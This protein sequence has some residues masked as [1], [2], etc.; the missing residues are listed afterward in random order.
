[1]SR[2][3]PLASEELGRTSEASSGAQILA[4]SETVMRGLY[5]GTM[6]ALAIAVVTGVLRTW[7]WVLALEPLALG[8]VVGE[9]AAAPSSARHRQPPRWSYG[10]IFGVSFAAYL[11]IHLIFWLASTGIPPSMSLFDFLRAAPTATVLF[12][13]VDLQRQLSL[14]TSGAA[15]FKYVLWLAE[16]LLMGLAACIAYRGG[17]VRT[18]GT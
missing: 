2:R 8:V 5:I 12:R 4:A 13:G 6:V 9:A 3:L 15:E 11:L 10:Y 17:S 7:I 1:M 18:L 16:G 14:A